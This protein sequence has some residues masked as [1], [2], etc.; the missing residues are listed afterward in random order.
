M[1]GEYKALRTKF[2]WIVGNSPNTA[3]I[4]AE[5]DAYRETNVTE[6]NVRQKYLVNYSR[7]VS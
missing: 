6:I 5:M 3:E 1:Y 7:K 2:I 4:K